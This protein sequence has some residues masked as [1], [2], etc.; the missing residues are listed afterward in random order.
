[1]KQTPNAS[2]FSEIPYNINAEK[3]C[4]FINNFYL[5]DDRDY[6]EKT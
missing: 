2:L 6:T 5:Q 4:E 3:I 1:M